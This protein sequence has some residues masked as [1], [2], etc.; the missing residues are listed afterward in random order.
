MCGIAGFSVNASLPSGLTEHYLHAM[1]DAIAHRGPD[2]TSLWHDTQFAM[3]HRRLSIIDLSAAGTQPMRSPCGRYVIVF[4]GE[5]YNYQI[6]KQQLLEQGAVFNTQTDTEVL[7]KL[8]QRDGKDCLT[9]L[10]GMFAFVVWDTSH[11][12]SSV[13]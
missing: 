1:G 12:C 13:G 6:L 10:N 4:N 7:L 9:H 3:V 2:A 5:I 11:K 8:F